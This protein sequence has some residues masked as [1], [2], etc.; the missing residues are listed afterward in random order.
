MLKI[1]S[2]KNIK[3]NVKKL[4]EAYNYIYKQKETTMIDINY[5]RNFVNINNMNSK[6]KSFVYFSELGLEF[7]E[8]ESLELDEEVINGVL[9]MAYIII[10]GHHVLSLYGSEDYLFIGD[11]KDNKFSFVSECGYNWN[12]FKAHVQDWLVNPKYIDK[13]NEVVELLPKIN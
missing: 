12:N 10:N 3:I 5:A 11:S 7:G 13:L 1:I 8:L 2:K 9:E 6:G 4:L